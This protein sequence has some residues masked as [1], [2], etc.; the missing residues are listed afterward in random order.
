[1]AESSPR[2]FLELWGWAEFLEA[3]GLTDAGLRYQREQYPDF[4]VPVAEL[5]MGPVFLASECR[6]Y[7]KANA[8]P[9]GVVPKL[10]LRRIYRMKDE[11]ASVNEIAA[12][13]GVSVPTI[14]RRLAQRRNK[15]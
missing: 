7:I 4:P 6:D 11:G 12:E 8:Q 3:S 1:M 10:V 2:A 15:S 14:Y 9:R 13:T 5:R